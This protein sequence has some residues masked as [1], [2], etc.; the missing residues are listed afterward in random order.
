[1]TFSSSL[2]TCAVSPAETLR[3]LTTPSKGARTIVRPA[4]AG[5]RDQVALRGFA[6]ALRGVAA[7]LGVLDLLRRNEAAVA[8]LHHALV[9]P[10]RLL[11]GLRGG[12]GRGLRRGQRVADGGVVES[13]QQLP[14]LHGVAV[15]LQHREHHRGDFGA[16]V[17]ALLR[18][19]GAGDD[20]AGRQRLQAQLQQVFGGQQQRG[21]RGCLVSVFRA[22]LALLASRRKQCHRRDSQ[23]QR[24]FSSFHLNSPKQAGVIDT[25]SESWPGL[26]PLSFCFCLGADSVV[27]ARPW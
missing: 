2:P 14:L 1:M 5:A 6:I 15:L 16:Q 4:A 7:H 8:Q 18:Q 27:R 13:H 22:A 10:L 23:S 9:L 3:S 17:R 19:D 11:V 26:T 21:K 24:N 25:V 20:R 12:V